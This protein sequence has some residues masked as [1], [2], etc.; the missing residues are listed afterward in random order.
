MWSALKKIAQGKSLRISLVMARLLFHRAR[1]D[2][3][4][5]LFSRKNSDRLVLLR[6]SFARHT[7]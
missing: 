7:L 2:D 4:L 5:I 1:S 3:T 6:D